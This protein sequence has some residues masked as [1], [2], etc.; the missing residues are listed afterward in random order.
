LIFLLCC[1][2]AIRVFIY[3]AAFPFFNN[4]DEQPNFDLV[5]K[6]SHLQIPRGL[7]LYSPEAV[8]DI[9]LYQSYAFLGQPTNLPPWR[10]S[11]DEAGQ[12]LQQTNR[13]QAVTNYECSQPP[14]YYLLA[15]GWRQ[16]GQAIGLTGE[17]SLYWLRFLNILFAIALVLLAYRTARW[18]FP[19]NDFI[20]CGVP[21]IAACLPQS[22]FFAINNDMLSAISFGLVFFW[23][24]KFLNAPVP[25]VPAGIALGLACAAA[26]LTKTTTLPLLVIAGIAIVIQVRRLAQRNQ[27]RAAGPGL[28]ALVICA[29]VPAG[30]WMAWCKSHYGDITGAEIKAEHFRWIHRPISEWWH[31]PIFT[32]AG[33]WTFLSMLL[34]TLWQ[35]EFVWHHQAMTPAIII[36]FYAILSLLALGCAAK[37][38]FFSASN[39]SAG[40]SQA[41][42]LG[43]ALVITAILF[44]AWLST[45]FDFGSFPYPSRNLPYFLSGRLILGALVPFLLIFVYA[46]DRAFA[47]TERRTK[48]IMLSALLVFMVTTGLL[49]TLPAFASQYNWFHL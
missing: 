37:F 32:P 29:A 2:A 39:L 40:Q 35:G 31:H 13:W 14:L 30:L 21:A 10:L 47:G 24:L 27:C 42:R 25:S 1:L 33:L 9:V 26:F 45:T 19:E 43:F 48:W 28:T 36:D 12:I 16:V 41:L 3:S 22:I 6:Y 34:G 38:V 7:D 8:H 17:R 49:A 46:L 20:A 44:W 18:L 11:S 4:I 5:V 23:L 15:G